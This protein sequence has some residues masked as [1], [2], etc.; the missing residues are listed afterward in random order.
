MRKIPSIHLCEI[1]FREFLIPMN[2]TA[3][4]LA[5]ETK[6]NPTRVSEIVN[7]EYS[8]IQRY[9]FLSSSEFLL[10]SEWESKTNMRFAQRGNRISWII[11]TSS[12]DYKTSN[13]TSVKFVIDFPISI[14][15][16]LE[17]KELFS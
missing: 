16:S 4:R 11:R 15:D 2:V 7:K 1:L 10:N 12:D 9:A 8:M 17:V 5:K 3:Y 6:I 13:P 14:N